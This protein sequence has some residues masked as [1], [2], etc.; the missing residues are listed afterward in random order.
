MFKNLNKGQGQLDYLNKI[1]VLKDVNIL[2]LMN[3]Q[4]NERCKFKNFWRF[5]KVKRREIEYMK[6]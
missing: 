6:R 4:K 5:W 1:V 2:M 3:N